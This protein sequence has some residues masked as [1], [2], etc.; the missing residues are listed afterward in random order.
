MR[1]LLFDNFGWKIAS[2]VLAWLL[3]L[4]TVGQPQ[5]TRS[6]SVP[7]E[8]QNLPPD[9]E[10]LSDIPDRARLEVRGPANRLEPSALPDIAVT[11]DLSEVQSPGIRGFPIDNTNVT[12][13]SAVTLERVQPGQIRLRF[14]RRAKR[15]VPVQVHI[16]VAPPRFE[17]VEVETDPKVISISGPE[18]HVSRITSAQTDPL[19]LSDWNGVDPVTVNAFVD[20]EMIR[21]DQGSRVV[22]K[23]TAVKIGN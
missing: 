18:S 7:L 16:A 20:D 10:I 15:D 9:L 6:I 23:I 8:F 4:A 19:D 17:I 12:L 5:I 21:F 11:I 13:P 22:V 3:W 2:L 1:G 14:E